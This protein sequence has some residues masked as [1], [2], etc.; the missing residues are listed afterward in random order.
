MQTIYKPLSILE[1]SKSNAIEYL[2]TAT[3]QQ[4]ITLLSNNDR[5]GIYLDELCINEFGQ[6]LTLDEL[7][8][9]FWLNFDGI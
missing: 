6:I 9:S 4:L 3:R 8:R 5:N 7:K 2:K 1:Q